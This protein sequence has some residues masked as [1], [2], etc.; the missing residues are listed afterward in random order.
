MQVPDDEGIQRAIAH[1]EAMLTSEDAAN[2]V[3]S[4]AATF[5]CLG[6]A[7]EE[8][9]KLQPASVSCYEKA[10]EYVGRAGHPEPWE[11]CVL[12]QQL[13]AVC[14]RLGR[15]KEA[16]KWLEHCSRACEEADGHPRDA[17]LFQRSFSTSQTRLEFAVMVAKLRAKT[18]MDMGNETRA[19]EFVA[20]AKALQAAL[21]G[22]AVERQEA[23]RPRAKAS[24]ADA[25]KQLWAEE[26][27]EEVILKEYR[28]M[29]EGPTVLVMLDLNEHTGLGTEASE[30]VTSLRQFR[31]NCQE[32]ALQIDLR[33]RRADGRV[34]QYRL[35]LE[36]LAH[37]II[38]ED[39]VPKLRGKEGKRRLEVKL[40]KRE[41]DRRWYG[42]LVCG[43]PPVAPQTKTAA[44]ASKEPAKGTILNPLTAEEIAKLPKPGDSAGY[45]RPSSFRANEVEAIAG[46][47]CP[48]PEQPAPEPEPTKEQSQSSPAWVA[49]VLR[50]ETDASILLKVRLDDALESVGL[51]NLALDVNDDQQILTL[52]FGIRPFAAFRRRRIAKP[53]WAKTHW[54]AK[55]N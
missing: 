30:S 52:H 12:L 16:D 7:L 4:P 14:L 41:K 18:S 37:E 8:K 43:T 1:M 11:H 48:A 19:R 20:E 13:G 54:D 29:D 55:P 46:S 10:L 34:S 44:P 40:F 22:D 26:P 39:T 27:A 31:V 45:N 32:K 17:V 24:T 51:D 35:P 47:S 53:H 50:E 25:S 42:D 36:P 9:P 2:V 21:S 15:L 33:L 6:M 49:D 23:G 5:V 38:P 3:G 28:F